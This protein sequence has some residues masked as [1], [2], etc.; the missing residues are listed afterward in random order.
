MMTANPH[1]RDTTN[2]PLV[3][4]SLLPRAPVRTPELSRGYAFAWAELGQKL[5]MASAVSRSP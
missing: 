2:E 3:D 5:R 1:L 4:L